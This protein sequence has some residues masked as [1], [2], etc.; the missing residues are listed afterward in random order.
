MRKMNR[1]SFG[2][3][4]RMTTLPTTPRILEAKGRFKGRSE[5]DLLLRHPNFV[6]KSADAS[7]EPPPLACEASALTTELTAQNRA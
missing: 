4:K 1:V 2:Q 5:K 3:E 6:A 7:F